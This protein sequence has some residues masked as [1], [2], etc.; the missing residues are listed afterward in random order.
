MLLSNGVK[1]GK[2]NKMWVNVFFFD[3]LQHLKGGGVTV[4]TLQSNSN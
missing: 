2:N 1:M 4:Y 3:V